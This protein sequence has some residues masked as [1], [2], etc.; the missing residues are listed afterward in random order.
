MFLHGRLE[1]IDGA[2]IDKPYALQRVAELK[3]TIG[4]ATLARP[5]RIRR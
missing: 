3:H 1:R 4:V 5:K 2:L